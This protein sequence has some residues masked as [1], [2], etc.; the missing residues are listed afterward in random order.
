M[1]GMVLISNRVPGGKDGS[2]GMCKS[3]VRCSIQCSGLSWGVTSLLK[4]RI[5][6]VGGKPEARSN[7]HKLT[8]GKGHPIEL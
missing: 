3:E 6:V 5:L 7:S 4:G 2:N 1:L 8:F